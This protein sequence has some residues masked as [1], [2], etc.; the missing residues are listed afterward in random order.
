MGANSETYVYVGLGSELGREG[1]GL[2]RR[3][4]EEDAWELA[5]RGLPQNPEI[6]TITI[7]PD[8]PA[9]LY[10][11]AQ[12][13]AYR[14]DDRGDHWERLD[15]PGEP[16]TIWSL[17][18]HPHNPQV[19]YAGG[20]EAK[21]FRSQDG[22][23]SWDLVPVRVTFPSVTMTPR[24]LPKRIIGLA[25]DPN[26]PEEMYA[27]VEVG[28]LLRSRDGGQSWEGISEGHYQNDDPVDMHGVLVSSTPSRRI[29]VISR[30]GMF[31]SDDG[32]DHWSW[33]NVERLGSRGTYCRVIREA[34]D[35]PSTIYIGAGPEF[36]GQPGALFRSHDLGETWQKVDTGITA[37]TTIFGFSIN[38]RS[39]SHMYCGTRGG[40]V[41][42]SHDGGETWHDFS[43]PDGAQ[44][45]NALVCG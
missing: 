35:D 33:G 2:Y 45:I 13:R 5:T 20:E 34:P 17:T 25:V 9:V 40:Q 36:R 27:A 14:S 19:I 28:G 1:Y 21:L 24:P 43:L 15:L 38:P 6:R 41:L 8:N 32:G 37:Q 30:V 22:G 3:A 10:A 16:V 12:D 39:P 18:F 26:R 29:S 31:R 44:E 42:G 23:K 4:A 7:A 11:S